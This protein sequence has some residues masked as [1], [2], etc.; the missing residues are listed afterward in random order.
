MLAWVPLETL[1]KSCFGPVR[2]LE[3]DYH[4]PHTQKRNQAK[5]IEPE[6]LHQQGRREGQAQGN[7]VELH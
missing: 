7:P 3:R 1:C 4:Q 2:S 6:L 5:G